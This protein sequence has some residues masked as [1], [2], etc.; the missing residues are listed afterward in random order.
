M[1]E[2][3][4]R[5]IRF[6]W[7]PAGPSSRL[8]PSLSMSSV[9]E[10]P[11]SSHKGGTSSC[12]SLS[13]YC[14]VTLEYL[15][16]KRTERNFSTK[17]RSIRAPKIWALH[18]RINGNEQAWSTGGKKVLQW[19]NG[20]SPKVNEKQRKMMNIK[21]RQKPPPPQTQCKK[22]EEKPYKMNIHAN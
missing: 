8:P 3:P 1:L 20:T 10:K 13:P 7:E 6:P 4:W 16:Q 9:F 22:P 12:K 21:T 14:P 2:E 11:C 15:I 18:L 17:R 5:N 19:E